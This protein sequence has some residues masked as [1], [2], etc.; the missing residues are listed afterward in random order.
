MTAQKTHFGIIK[1]LPRH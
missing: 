1:N